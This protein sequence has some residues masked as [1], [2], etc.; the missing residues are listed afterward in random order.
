MSTLKQQAYNRVRTLMGHK[1]DWQKQFYDKKVHG[2]PYNENDLVWLYTTVV[3]KGVGRKLHRPWNGPLRVVRRIS[4]SLYRLQSTHSSRHRV[5]IHFDCLKPY[6]EN[7]RTANLQ[8]KQKHPPHFAST[9]SYHNKSLMMTQWRNLFLVI[10]ITLDDPLIVSFQL[11]CIELESGTDFFFSG[12]C[13]ICLIW[14]CCAIELL[15]VIL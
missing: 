4:D 2:Q 5:I 9:T 11:F 15:Q 10:L 3:P 13:V 1:L 8:M 12:G 14:S 6:P 7:I